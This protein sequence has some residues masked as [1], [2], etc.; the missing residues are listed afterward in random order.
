MSSNLGHDILYRISKFLDDKSCLN[1]SLTNRATFEMIHGIQLRENFMRFNRRVVALFQPGSAYAWAIKNN[2]LALLHKIFDTVDDDLLCELVAGRDWSDEAVRTLAGV[3]RRRV[4]HTP[5][6]FLKRT[7]FDCLYSGNTAALEILERRIPKTFAKVIVF[8]SHG[9]VNKA[10]RLSRANFLRILQRAGYPKVEWEGDGI[11]AG[12]TPLA[13]ETHFGAVLRVLIE[14]GADPI[15]YQTIPNGGNILHVRAIEGQDDKDLLAEYI[16]RGQGLEDLNLIT[17]PPPSNLNGPPQERGQ[18]LVFRYTPLDLAC[19]HKNVATIMN[20]VSL[21]AHCGGS[22][23]SFSLHNP[24]WIPTTPLHEMFERPGMYDNS[25]AHAPW[26]YRGALSFI[27]LN[28]YGV[29]PKKGLC[30]SQTF[31]IRGRSTCRQGGLMENLVAYAGII[32]TGVEILLDYGSKSYINT[33]V[34]GKG[35]PL[36]FFLALAVEMRKHQDFLCVDQSLSLVPNHD[37][38]LV[39][40]FGAGSVLLGALGN[41]CDLLIDAGAR[42]PFEGYEGGEDERGKIRL[43]RLLSMC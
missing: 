40:V 2:K 22:Y 4:H 29:L 39:V 19:Q 38:P 37:C 26:N 10:A 36:E 7:V 33:S 3:Q 8:W 20:L 43:E 14:M 21:G 9:W 6:N 32:Q 41:I 16:D 18:Q 31:R 1:L 24:T 25:E 13:W 5:T 12:L 27:H 42:I 30:S 17:R 35:T 23:N 11:I 28:E 34:P 15:N